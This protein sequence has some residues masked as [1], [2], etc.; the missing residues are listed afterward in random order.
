MTDKILAEHLNLR[1]A[2]QDDVEN[3]WSLLGTYAKE[4][5][6]LPRSQADILEKLK[7]FRVAELDGKFVGCVAVRD[8]GDDL[9]EVRSLA[10]VKEYNERG[11]GSAIVISV[12]N[13]LRKKERP[14]RLFALTYRGHFFQRLGFHIVDKNEFPEK[15]WSDCAIC[16]KRENCDETAVLINLP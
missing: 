12:C 16:P 3:I 15:I 2:G 14:I 13:F 4:R 1:P 5:L 9:Y 10:V 8:Y 7:N 11:I 6:L